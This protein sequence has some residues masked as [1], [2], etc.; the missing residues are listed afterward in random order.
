MNTIDFTTLVE[1]Y[2]CLRSSS[3]YANIMAYLMNSSDDVLYDTYKS[4][5]NNWLSSEPLIKVL[6]VDV[7][8]VRV[9]VIL[10][11]G[12]TS[13]D[14]SI[15]LSDNVPNSKNVF[16]NQGNRSYNI[17]AFLTTSG[18]SHQVKYSNTIKSD[19]MYYTVRQGTHVE[20]LGN[21]VIAL[22]I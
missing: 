7:S 6:G 18:I 17:S 4:E 16:E 12:K 22:K 20:P 8:N 2:N 10:A 11:D 3:A 5:L 15:P 14:S 21:I 19:E 13:F 9:M 1:T